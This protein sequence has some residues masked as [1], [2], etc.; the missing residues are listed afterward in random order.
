M[1]MFLIEHGSTCSLKFTCIFR[2]PTFVLQ[3]FSNGMT[4]ILCFYF[5][6][7]IERNIKVNNVSYNAQFNY[8]VSKL[9]AHTC[10][11]LNNPKTD[12][13]ETDFFY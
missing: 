3:Y 11:C 10:V 6:P 13:T 5:L 8:A 2:L 12:R 9:T 4:L 7:E 1:Q